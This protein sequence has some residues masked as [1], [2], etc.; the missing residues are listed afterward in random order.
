M[1]ERPNKQILVAL[2]VVEYQ[3]KILML[4]RVS[5]IPNW[6]HRWNIPGGKAL[7]GESPE[8]AVRREVREEAGIEI[9]PLEFLGIHTHH[10]TL[11]EH[12]QQTFLALY[13]APALHDRVALRHEEND[14]HCWVALDEC[15]AMDNLLDGS[16]EML[17]ALYEPRVRPCLAV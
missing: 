12:T 15:Y 9:G 11:P 1:V 2:G 10:W 17:R 13:R 6:H 8:D 16:I 4:R 3:G 7:A 14:A 5:P